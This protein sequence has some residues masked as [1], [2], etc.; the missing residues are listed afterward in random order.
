MAPALSRESISFGEFELD[1]RTAE[2]RRNG[3]E[4]K[5]QPQPA[6]VLLILASRAGEVVTRDELTEQVW[7]SDTFVDFEHGLNFAIRQ[8]RTALDDDATNPSFVETVHRR[9][10]RFIATVSSN[11]HTKLEHPPAK[12]KAVW[13]MWAALTFLV[14]GAVGIIWYAREPRSKTMESPILLADFVNN[15]RDPIFDRAL[16][17]GLSVQLE[18]SPF[19][20]LVSDEQIR[21]TLRMMGRA[22]NTELS[23]EVARELCQRTN[24]AVTLAGSI[25]LIGTRYAMHLRAVDCASRAL[26]G[27]A[28]ARAEDKDQVLD[29]L[30]NLASDIRR[31]LGESLGSIRQ[32]NKPVAA[33]TTPSLEALRCYTEGLRVMAEKFDY[34]ES[35]SWFRKAIE[36]DPNF[37]LAYWAM[38][39][40]YAILGETG[41]AVQFTRRAFE[42]RDPV[43][44]REREL[45]EANYYYYVLG[46]VDKARRSCE[47][48]ANLYPYNE[49][50][51][52]SL[53]AFAETIGRYDVGL[54]EYQEALRLAPWRSFLY[55]DV[56][57]TDLMLDR[58]DE[59]TSM[60]S[61]AHEMG[62]DENLGVTR[63]SIAFYRNDRVEMSRQLAN[64]AGNPE[65]EDLL[66]ALDADTAAFAGQLGRARVLSQR[67]AASA[68]RNLKNETSASYYASSALREALFGNFKN[69][70][71]QVRIAKNH[72]SGRDVAY[73]IALAV[74]YSGDMNQARRLIEDFATRFPDDTVVKCNYLP[75]LNA[76]L[77]LLQN[78]PLHAIEILTPTQSCELGLPVYSYY[79]WL[80][81]YPAYVRGEAYLAANQGK[82][83]A[84]EFEKVA[85]H[86]GITLN[87]PIGAL[88]HLQLGRAYRLA[89]D[90]TKSRAHYQ[91]F[92]A[93]W[94]DADSDIPF[95]KSA[96]KE[97][98][99]LK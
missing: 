73:G 3:T 64:A 81:L 16:R 71:E 82:D 63:Y 61:K 33:A 42:L 98:A 91:D 36:I 77:A 95:L 24:A 19:L 76:R 69:S 60:V 39:D 40:V 58:V 38:G 74:T 4:L 2:L 20:R 48:L 44:E 79:N 53:A 27:S 86:R 75:T 99:K 68:E 18:Q 37:A 5:L 55:R 66:L 34:A 88:A 89:G 65:T 23:P 41:E 84:A 17:Q 78:N 10:Y 87:E 28:E 93:L 31:K 49:D 22:S 96:K 9:G 30:T 29:A 57:N 26:L 54:R 62:L 7:G 72:S 70:M 83:A 52:T 45:I 90:A 94:K 25:E 21:E 1:C 13:R 8:I 80:N 46:D 67:A 47:L 97:F 59:A 85:S 32:Y 56:A 50:A 6:K 11:G 35:L 51:H 12:G 92:F 43:S 15:T 14:L